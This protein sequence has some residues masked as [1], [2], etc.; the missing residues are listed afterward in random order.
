MINHRRQRLLCPC[1]YF[2]ANVRPMF[3]FVGFALLPCPLHFLLVFY[4]III[5][6][7]EWRD[8]TFLPLPVPYASLLVPFS[9]KY[10]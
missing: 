3:M 8:I 9:G 2:A 6:S 10:T 5:F 4:I 7:N 1:V